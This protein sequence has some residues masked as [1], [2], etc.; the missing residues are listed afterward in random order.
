MSAAAEPTP[1]SEATAAACDLFAWADE[2]LTRD[3]HE[4][5]LWIVAM[6]VSKEVARSTDWNEGRP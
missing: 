2:T 1:L 4:V 3:E 6:R 5:W